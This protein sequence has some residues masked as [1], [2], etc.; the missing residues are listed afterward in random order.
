M[1]GGLLKECGSVGVWGGMVLIM[2]VRGMR[3]ALRVVMMMCLRVRGGRV[4]SWVLVGHGR[5]LGRLK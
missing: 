3:G 2:E 5:D 4:G 1:W